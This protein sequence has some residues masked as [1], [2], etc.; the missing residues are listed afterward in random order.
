LI[1]ALRTAL[2]SDKVITISVYWQ[3][4]LATVVQRTSGSLDQVNVMCYDMDQWSNDLFYNSATYG[5]IGDTAH[6]S[7]AMI[8]SNYSSYIPAQ[9]IGVGFPFYARIGRGCAEAGCPDG[10]HDPLQIWSGNP[11]SRSIHYNTLLASPYWSYPRAWAPTRQ[12]NYI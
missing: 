10:L 4:T 1:M 5:S 11:T 12:V 3:R 6:N 8:T 7:C 2:G 9:K